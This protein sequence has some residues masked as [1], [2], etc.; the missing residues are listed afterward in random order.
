[1]EP[2]F[3]VASFFININTGDAAIHILYSRA[4]A[5]AMKRVERAIL[6]DGGSQRTGVNHGVPHPNIDQTI[7][8]IEEQFQCQGRPNA[9]RNGDRPRLI[10]DAFVVSHWDDDHAEGV[11]W[12]LLRDVEQQIQLNI[13]LNQI[14][15]SRAWYE[16]P[17]NIPQSYFY[18]PTWKHLD[19]VKPTWGAVVWSSQFSNYFSTFYDTTIVPGDGQ[20]QLMPNDAMLWITPDPGQPNQIIKKLLLMRIGMEL[21]GRNFFAREHPNIDNGVRWKFTNI[22]E[23]L[24][25]VPPECPIQPEPVNSNVPGFYCVGTNA[26]VLGGV[27][28]VD[29]DTYKNETSICNL[30]IWGRSKSVSLYTAGDA[31]ENLERHVANWIGYAPTDAK[32]VR[33]MKVSHHGGDTSSPRELWSHLK[34]FHV[35]CSAGD[36]ATYCHPRK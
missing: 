9:G 7:I 22:S 17:G 4:D 11:M 26:F 10:F 31:P 14:T 36:H 24:A 3:G 23:L 18:A 8:D 29:S 33:I 12:F 19:H 21:L 30:V 16:Q 32:G 2:Y 1:M 13:P 5:L 27:T 28:S 20:D 34:P 25:S 35:V 15:L 6:L